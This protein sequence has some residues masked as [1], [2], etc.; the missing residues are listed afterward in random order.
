MGLRGMKVGRISVEY[1]GLVRKVAALSCALFTIACFVACANDRDSG[2]KPTKTLDSG[3]SR[4]NNGKSL[5]PKTQDEQEDPEE[6]IVTD[7]GSLISAKF[8]VSATVTQI[9]K[10]P[11]EYSRLFPSSGIGSVGKCGPKIFPMKVNAS[12]GSAEKGIPLI[13]IADAKL[14]CKAMDVIPMDLDLKGILSVFSNSK[15]VPDLTVESHVIFANRLGDGVYTPPRPFLPSFLASKKEDIARI[16][17]VKDGVRLT[18]SASGASVTGK[19]H[20]QTI[21]IKEKDVVEAG[22]FNDVIHFQTEISGFESIKIVK[23]SNFL[24]NK[25]SIWI[26]L[27]PLSI[28][29]IQMEAPATLFVKAAANNPNSIQGI[30]GSVI[31]GLKPIIEGNE[32]ILNFADSLTD[33]FHVVVDLELL[34]QEGIQQ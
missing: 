10:I 30:L 12:F 32:S 20:L 23:L 27:N 16:N 25:S 6:G 18:S 11:E 13:E 8:K 21:E 29:R 15:A 24:P 2:G 31:G 17:M 26:S 28:I 19:F 14:S 3:T 9:A 22:T 7:K 4:A 5:E 34:E 33:K 1:S